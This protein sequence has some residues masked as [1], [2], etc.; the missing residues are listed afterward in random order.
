MV[1]RL[2][3]SLRKAADPNVTA[4]WD[5][6]HFTGATAMES[7]KFVTD[8]LSGARLEGAE[9]TGSGV[10]MISVNVEDPHYKQPAPEA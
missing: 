9:V 10:E 7:A 6:S 8:R 5:I 3:M 2:L 1:S 4:T